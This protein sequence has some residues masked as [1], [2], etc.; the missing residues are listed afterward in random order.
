M[1]RHHPWLSWKL[2]MLKNVYTFN[3]IWADKGSRTIWV[4]VIV[5]SLIYWCIE[6]INAKY[7]SIFVYFDYYWHAIKYSYCGH[8]QKYFFFYSNFWR[9][10]KIP[11]AKSISLK[12]NSEWKRFE[13]W[14]WWCTRFFYIR[15]TSV[16]T[17]NLRFEL[18]YFSKSVFNVMFD[19]VT[20]HVF[21]PATL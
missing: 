13:I 6:N 8:D 1:V 11:I 20:S 15:T 17:A 9:V 4:M 19:T 3:Y 5:E 21:R 16:S 14:F 10:T 7:F 18:K 12:S 2:L